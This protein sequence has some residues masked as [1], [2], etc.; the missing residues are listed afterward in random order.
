LGFVL[1]LFAKQQMTLVQEIF[2][3]L[4]SPTYYPLQTKMGYCWPEQIKVIIESHGKSYY[5]NEIFYTD[6]LLQKIVWGML[7]WQILKL[8]KKYWFHAKVWFLKWKKDQKI[9]YLKHKLQAWPIVL[10][11]THAYDAKIR[12]NLLR[13]LWFHHYISI[14][15]YNE[16]EEI[17]YVYDSSISTKIRKDI[18]IG[19]TTFTY[20]E[21]IRYWKFPVFWLVRNM[22]IS[23]G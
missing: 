4:N 18:P 12:F 6:T 22:Y 13:A 19:N 20:D 9:S 8:L 5:K 16:K 21:L 11:I 3:I 15:W 17:F 14:W 1:I 7:P 23:L 10:M 2:T